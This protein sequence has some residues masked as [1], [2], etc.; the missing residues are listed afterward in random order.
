[1][2]AHHEHFLVVRPVEDRDVAAAGQP[3]RVSP[4]VVMLQFLGRRHLEAAHM[5]ALRVHAA[6][7]V[8]DRAVL[9]A[10]VDALQD[11]QDTAGGLCGQP[12]LIVGQQGNAGAEKLVRVLL[13]HEM[14]LVSRVE[15]FLQGHLRAWPDPQRLD[16]LGHAGDLLVG[17]RSVL[18]RQISPP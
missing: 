14:G 16:Q 5:D 9:A 18:P 7:H 6:H 12:R 8:P 13:P 2:N 10:S 17:H 3:L 1:M 4:Q 11:D 15:V